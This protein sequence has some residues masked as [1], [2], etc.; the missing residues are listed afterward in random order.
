LKSRSQYR[1][2]FIFKS[3]ETIEKE[4]NGVSQRKLTP[5]EAQLLR[6]SLSADYKIGNIRL[7]EGEYQHSLAKAIASFQLELHFPDV[8]DIAKRLYGDEKAGDVQFIRKIQ[9]IL[10]KMEKSGIIE[11]LPKKRPWDLQRYALSS[12][13]FQ[14]ADKNLVVFAS[15]QEIRQS[16]G[17][18]QSALNEETTLAARMLTGRLKTAILSLVVLVSYGAILW[19][20]MQPVVNPVIFIPVFS[21]AVACSLLLGK[22]LSEM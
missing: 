5:S 17:V 16:V 13:K 2:L 22:A 20:L 7:R 1:S 3:T 4:A 14:D 19:D 9:T 6:K 10:K 12:F 8:R 11:I 18:L 15:E 21:V